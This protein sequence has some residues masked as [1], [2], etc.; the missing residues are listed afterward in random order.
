[1]EQEKK[2]LLSLQELIEINKNA[3]ER[4]KL[5]NWNS[6]VD[7]ITRNL[8]LNSNLAWSESELEDDQVQEL[9]EKGFKVDFSSP[10]N[11]HKITW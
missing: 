10:N 11:C 1:M 3:K 6:T 8:E 4:R 9:I 2:E 5:K 7:S